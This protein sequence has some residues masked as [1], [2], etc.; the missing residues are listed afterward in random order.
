MGEY[1]LD[2]Y[3]PEHRLVIEIDGESHEF[4]GE[5]DS[6][7][8]AWL[9]SQGLCVLRFTNDDMLAEMEAVLEGIRRHL[10]P[11][12]PGRGRPRSGG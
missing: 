7:R 9:R 4:R 12:P 2:F 8:D 5:Y 10:I 6:G 1:I 3:S 11:S